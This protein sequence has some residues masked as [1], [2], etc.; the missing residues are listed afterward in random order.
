MEVLSEG[1][2][3]VIFDA[4][5]TLVDSEDLGLEVL[6]EHARSIG[7]PLRED[8]DIGALRG[9]S[10]A[11][12]LEL[13]ATLLGRALPPDF[14]Q[15]ARARMADAF[16]RHLLPMPGAREV[17]ERLSIPY[18]VAT[19]GPRHKVELT[20][21]ITGLLHLFSDRIFSAYEVGS[22]KPAPGLFLAAAAALGVPPHRCAVV[23]DSEPGI[24]AGL[25]ARM[26][27]FAVRSD[28]PLPPGLAARVQWLDR[29][30]DLLVAVPALH[31]RPA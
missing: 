30:E 8:E 28:R 25:A 21:R 23:E 6:A 22:F 5:G 11:S 10:M 26:R 15:Q 27:V 14:E 1:T 20:L 29:L 4:D 19:N 13:F 2:G 7:V 12:N 3:A 24:V 18:C 16:Q 17:V 9:K 31:G